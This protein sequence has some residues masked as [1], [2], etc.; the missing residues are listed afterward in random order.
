MVRST[1]ELIRFVASPDGEVIAD[2]KRTLPGR[3]VWVTATRNAIERAV[4]KNAFPRAL[5][6]EVRVSADLVERVERLLERFALDALGIA[7]KAGKVIVG[8]AR[9]EDALDSEPVLALLRAADA[10]PEGARKIDRKA[11]SACRKLA[12][13]K[14]F[15]S[16]QLDLAL[17]R[18]NVVHAALLAGQA[19][20]G[21]L[22][23]C[24]KL[25]RF[26]TDG[27]KELPGAS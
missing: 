8:F 4:R 26:R 23:R 1:E 3:G 5:K 27:S 22:A 18:A 12:V 19:S 24:R 14:L 15:R 9:V 2:L 16:A 21:F 13:V 6:R 17:G 10:S 20:E 7:H 25:E 11:T